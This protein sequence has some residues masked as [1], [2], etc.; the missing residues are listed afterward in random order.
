M[1]S[2]IFISGDEIERANA[3]ALGYAN[4]VGHPVELGGLAPGGMLV[5]DIDRIVFGGRDGAIEWARAAAESGVSVSLR[6]YYPDDPRLDELRARPNVVIAKTHRHLLK[7]LRGDRR[8]RLI[9]ATIEA[10]Q[11]G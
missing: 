4:I 5:L 1:I 3:R 8:T 2:G 9:R 11:S 7:A 6:T 10:N